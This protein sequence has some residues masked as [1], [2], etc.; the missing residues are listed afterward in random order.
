MPFRQVS[1]DKGMQ[2]LGLAEEFGA[3]TVNLAGGVLQGFF[4][5]IVFG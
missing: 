5:Q 3:D 2:R 1:I 4:Y